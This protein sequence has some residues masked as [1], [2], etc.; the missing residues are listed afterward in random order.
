MLVDST[1]SSK[2]RTGLSGMGLTYFARSKLIMTLLE[3]LM[4]SY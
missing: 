4:M 1:L 3:I 2:V